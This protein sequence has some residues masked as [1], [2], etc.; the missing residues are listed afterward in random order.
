MGSV[1][2]NQ[3]NNQSQSYI[4]APAINDLYFVDFAKVE[5]SG[6]TKTKHA[7]GVMKLAKIT[8]EGKYYFLI[9]AQ[10]YNKKRGAEKMLKDPA[11]IKFD[12]KDGMSFTNQQL[13]SLKDSSVIFDIVR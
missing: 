12:A 3:H 6:F 2:S 13:Q 10:G 9:S 11:A 7:Y 5:N 8:T 1:S 4:S